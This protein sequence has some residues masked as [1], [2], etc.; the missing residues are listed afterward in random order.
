[1]AL[2][3]KTQRKWNGGILGRDG[4][5][6][7]LPDNENCALLID[8]AARSLCMFGEPPIGTSKWCG[9]VLGS[10]GAVYGAPHNAT[11]VLK[12]ITYKRLSWS[13]GAHMHFPDRSRKIVQLLLLCQ[14]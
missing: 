11:C 13:P 7:G 4:L 6:Y 12:I 9:G 1:M 5:I 14:A 2:L 8:P 3:P 10:D